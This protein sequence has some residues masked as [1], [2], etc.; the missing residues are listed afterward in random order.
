VKHDNRLD[1]DQPC[2]EGATRIMRSEQ[3]WCVATSLGWSGLDSL[4]PWCRDKRICC[5]ATSL[6]KKLKVI[7]CIQVMLGTRT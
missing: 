6:G 7:A 5:V 1:S 2:R 3:T 4:V